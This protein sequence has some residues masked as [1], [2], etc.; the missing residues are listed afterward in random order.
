[1]GEGSGATVAAVCGGVTQGVGGW[2]SR[3]RV[4][5][6]GERDGYER[7]VGDFWGC[8]GRGSGGGVWGLTY[9]PNRSQR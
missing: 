3:F 7:V 6:L 8:E 1:M 9:P 2:G 5:A 4:R